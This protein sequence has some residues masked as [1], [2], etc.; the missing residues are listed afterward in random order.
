M[1]D[2]PLLLLGAGPVALNVASLVAG[3]RKVYGTTRQP[4]RIF[5]LAQAKIEPV[6]MPLPSTEIIAPLASGADVLVSF[7]PDGATD[8]VLAPSCNLARSLVYIS[9][10][11]VY[12]SY[13][14]QIDNTTPVDWQEPS[15]QQRLNAETVWRAAGA[16][17]LRVAGIYGPHSGLLKRLQD[18]TYKITDDSYRIISRIHIA[19]LAEIILALL[20]RGQTSRTYV[21]ADLHP[22]S[23][24][25]VVE[26]LCQHLALPL[27]AEQG[28]ESSE[29]E[30]AAEQQQQQQPEQG[31]QQHR[32]PT[33]EQRAT[34][35]HKVRNDRL[36]D[37]GGL[38]SDLGI[39][40]RYPTYKEGYIDCLQSGNSCQS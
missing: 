3:H 5:Q 7:P 24:L 20:E 25:E 1:S 38:L 29:E 32:K 18:G 28:E 35:S 33:T 14:G 21:C 30:V 31:K 10:T 9:S 4:Q 11:R 26:W 13:Q 15:A 17:I 8:A 12:G 34:V 27:P 16:T 22:S 19:D 2:S 37:S 36:V 39:T 6:V 23:Q 40:L